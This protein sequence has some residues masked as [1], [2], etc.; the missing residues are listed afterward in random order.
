MTASQFSLRAG[1]PIE[2]QRAFDIDDLA[3]QLYIAAGLTITIADDHPFV[4][5]ERARWAEAARVGDLWFGTLDG[6][7]VG[8]YAMS[9]LD[10]CAYLDQLA[11]LPEYG[12]RGLGRRLIE[13]ASARAERRGET[14]LWLTTY[15]HFPWN[16]PFYERCGFS[17]V[18]APSC[19]AEVLAALA[20]Q[21]AALP[22]PEYRVAMRRAL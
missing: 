13:H 20:E 14:A 9:S 12:R 15:D 21:R 16:R 7:P 6:V 17:V 10:G 11:V 1:T 5:G 3:L 8:F 19:G 22:D 2:V 4:I 18:P